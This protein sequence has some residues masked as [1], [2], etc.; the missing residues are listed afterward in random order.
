MT[1]RSEG[2]NVQRLINKVA[3]V[4]GGA[5]GLGKEIAWRLVSEGATVVIN[6]SRLLI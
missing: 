3:L 1:L 6:D 4:T 5:S 2:G